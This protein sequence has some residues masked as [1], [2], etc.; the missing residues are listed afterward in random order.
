MEINE[1]TKITTMRIPVELHNKITEMAKKYD[2]S[3]TKQVIY[4]LKQY[5]EFQEQK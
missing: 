2:R 5:I 1:E 3:F 4:M